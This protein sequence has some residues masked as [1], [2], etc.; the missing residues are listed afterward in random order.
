MTAL[1]PRTLRVYL[2]AFYALMVEYRAEIFLWAIATSLPLIMMGVWIEAADSG[3]F[4]GFTPLDAARYFIAVFVVRQITICWVIHDFEYLVVSGKLSPML[5]H[6]IDPIYRFILMHLGEHGARAPFGV[7]LVV[8]CF[9]IVPDALLGN[10][11]QPGAWLPAWW[12]ILLALVASYGAFLLRFIIQYTTAIAA[13]W[14]ERVSALDGINYLPYIFLSGL[15]VP[16]H[17]LPDYL[18]HIVLWTPFPYM[19]WFPAQL[20]AAPAEQITAAFVIRGFATLAGWGVVIFIVNRWLW[21][22]GLKHYS[23]MGA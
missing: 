7:L 11:D 16:I 6:P 20:V 9:V 12:R 2:T 14:V 4:A 19:L 13:F 22:R 10:A 15:T 5:L 17:L 18:Q 21:K 1:T 23:A 3:K 8:L